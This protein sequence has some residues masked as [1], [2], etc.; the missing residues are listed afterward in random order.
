MMTA[1]AF[2]SISTA[3]HRF[4]GLRR[5]VLLPN[6]PL[7]RR[8]GPLRASEGRSQ[9]LLEVHQ[10]LQV[11]AGGHHRHRKVRSR[12]ADRTDQLPTHLIDGREHVLDPGVRLRDALV[13]ALL[14]F[15]K[16][17]VAAALPLDLIAIAV[18]LEPTLSV[19]AGVAPIRID[20]T[21]GVAPVNDRF[22]V[23]AVMDARGAGLE[24]PD[25]L[26]LGV[27]VDR[28]LVSEVVLA[29]LL[30]PGRIRVFLAPFG[31]LPVGRHRAFPD[32]L[33]LLTAVALL[34]HRH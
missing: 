18:L 3:N 14:T 33:V 27:D 4:P 6:R 21:A 5:P 22:E 25:D 24:L 9:G 19:G 7:Q 28:E 10:P 26:V 8:F 11:V 1:T 17:L 32:Q 12:L 29:V 13:A 23:L 15:G 31:W 30:C 20:I 2:G 16:G 34:R